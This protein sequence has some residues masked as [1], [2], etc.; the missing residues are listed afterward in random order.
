MKTEYSEKE[1][2]LINYF[3]FK[4]IIYDCSI[5]PPTIYRMMVEK[6]FSENMN[7]KEVESL[8]RCY[9]AL[10]KCKTY[11]MTKEWDSMID[12]D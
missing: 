3:G 11:R 10:V 4:N 2:K 7:G 6:A 9:N 1:I 8:R 12:I 5:L